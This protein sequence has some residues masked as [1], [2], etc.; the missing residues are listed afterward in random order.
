MW[1]C[2]DEEINVRILMCCVHRETVRHSDHRDTGDPRDAPAVSSRLFEEEALACIRRIFA[3]EMFDAC[4]FIGEI[5]HYE[6]ERVRIAS[7]VFD[8]MLRLESSDATTLSTVPFSYPIC[9]SEAIRWVLRDCFSSRGFFSRRD[10]ISSVPLSSTT[11]FCAVFFPIHGTEARR[12]SS[13]SSIAL[14][15]DSTPRPRSESA[16]FPQIP[17]T[18]R[19]FWKSPFSS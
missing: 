4:V 18:F 8:S 2:Y 6:R 13:W 10:R 11:I 9:V 12:L 16:V 3:S 15:S 7:T 14:T 1:S 5:V 17:F 19:S